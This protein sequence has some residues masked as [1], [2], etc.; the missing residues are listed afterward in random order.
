MNLEYKEEDLQESE[1]IHR[2]LVENAKNGIALTD[3]ERK[4]LLVNKALAKMV[5]Y[6]RDELKGMDIQEVLTEDGAKK[7]REATK[8]QINNNGEQK[9][10]TLLQKEGKKIP[11]L[12]S[13]SPLNTRIGKP[14]E[15][16]VVVTDITSQKK[17]QENLINLHKWHRKLNK[18]ENMDEIYTYTLD[19]IKEIL[20]ISHS[21]FLLKRQKFLSV[22]KQ[23]GFDSFSLDQLKLSLSK[24]PPSVQAAKSGKTI[25]IPNVK[26][27]P[28]YFQIKP[29]VRSELVVPI[30]SEEEVLGVLDLQSEKVR[31]FNEEDIRLLEIL[32][33]HLAVAINNL[34]SKKKLVPQKELEEQREQFLE[35]GA[36]KIKNPLTSIKI[37]LESLLEG[38]HGKLTEKQNTK[39]KKAIK[40]VDRV[41]RLL[42]DFRQL[43]RLRNEQVEL[44][45]KKHRLPDTIEE[46]LWKY[47]E[48]I[49]D[50]KI[51]VIKNIPRPFKAKYD[52]EQI[53]QVIGNLMENAIDHTADKIWITCGETEGE[54]WLS[55]RDNG[56]GI[57]MRDQEKIFESFYR[58]EGEWK[59]DERRFGGTG[60]GL[61]ISKEIMQAHGGEI[62]VDSS[63]GEGSSFTIT[64]PKEAN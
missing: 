48:I 38:Y 64:I 34:K 26:R 29:E 32:A 47:K 51:R 14:Q 40:S 1:K 15:H 10:I 42:K 44:D 62:Q 49:V 43:L 12:V 35:M 4:F 27:E 18:A 3:R 9:E 17:R 61:T 63:P 21:L 55:V 36:D 33:S 57:P 13:I 59:R 20:K 19:T 7:F 25:N 56:P 50:K 22:V 45:L 2:I 41:D 52:N 6:S 37:D 8:N 39:L 53:I 16:I 60:L 23:R 30:K 11:A 5:D 46:A 24:Q 28:S 54:V 31:A 58:V